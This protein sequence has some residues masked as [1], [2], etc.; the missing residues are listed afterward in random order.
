MYPFDYSAALGRACQS[1]APSLPCLADAAKGYSAAPGRERQPRVA[2]LDPA[3]ISIFHST[4]HILNSPSCNGVST[5]PPPYPLFG[6][7]RSRDG[8]VNLLS[9]PR[10]HPPDH[11]LLKEGPLSSSPSLPCH[12]AGQGAGRQPNCI[13]PCV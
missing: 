6:H 3:E 10:R 1:T 5:S 2:F 11:R 8:R 7:G 13:L 4:F 9:P 12:L